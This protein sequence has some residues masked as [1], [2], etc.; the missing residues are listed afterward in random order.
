MLNHM[1]NQQS[2]LDDV[3]G[4]LSSAVRRQTIEDLGSGARTI[5]E[6]AAPHDMSLAGFMKHL[7]VLTDVGLVSC[8]KDG[9]TVTCTL[10][11]APL[12]QAS[13]WLSSRERTLNDRMDALGRHLYHREQV[14]AD[15]APSEKPESGPS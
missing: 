13:R 1:V 11:D 14:D 6:L 9:R 8:V 4:A 12:S 10:V 7:R 5:S 3:F 15:R 2:A